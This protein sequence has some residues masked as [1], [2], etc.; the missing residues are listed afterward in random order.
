MFEGR[1]C[2]FFKMFATLIA[3]VCVFPVP[4]P[5][6]TITGPSIVSTARF[7]AGLSALYA[8]SN[9]EVSLGRFVG[10]LVGVDMGE[11]V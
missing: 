9:A 11:G 8:D 2:V 3:S 1:I 10:V 6:T 7:W 4:G 5:A